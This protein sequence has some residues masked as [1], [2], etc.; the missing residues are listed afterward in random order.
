MNLFEVDDDQSNVISN[1]NVLVNID[2]GNQFVLSSKTDIDK[3]SL[4]DICTPLEIRSME[5]GFLNYLP[6]PKQFQ[7]YW[8]LRS[9]I[10][11]GETASLAHGW[12]KVENNVDLDNETILPVQLL[13]RSI[14]EIPYRTRKF[15]DSYVETVIDI[16]LTLHIIS[17]IVIER[18][19]KSTPKKHVLVSALKFR[20]AKELSEAKKHSFDVSEKFSDDSDDSDDL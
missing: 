8:K 12:S 3:I 1:T 14:V 6:K 15:Q 13:C 2:D 5:K 16:L 9:G 20:N 17:Q 4:T 18:E 7:S 11:V 10:N 19:N